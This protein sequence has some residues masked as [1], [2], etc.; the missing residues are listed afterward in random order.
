MNHPKPGT[1]VHIAGHVFPDG[2]NRS[3]EITLQQTVPGVTSVFVPELE[4]AW[5][6]AT[7]SITVNR[8]ES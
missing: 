1:W 4:A 5:P 6:F 3:G 8:W 7:A 2:R